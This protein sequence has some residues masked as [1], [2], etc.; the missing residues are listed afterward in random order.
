MNPI[1]LCSMVL[2]PPPNEKI[3]RA[4]RHCRPG[5][6]IHARG[7]EIKKELQEHARKKFYIIILLNV[8]DRW[9]YIIKN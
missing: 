4:Q 3:N 2:R 6:N 1:Y 8:E 7:K 9:L 5:K